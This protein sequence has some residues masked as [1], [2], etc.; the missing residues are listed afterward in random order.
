MDGPVHP[1]DSDAQDT[2]CACVDGLHLEKL[3]GSVWLPNH[4]PSP[5]PQML[6]F[7]IKVQIEEGE[8]DS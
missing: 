5:L 3:Q 2:Q 6:D 7:Q 4:H 8:R 1:L